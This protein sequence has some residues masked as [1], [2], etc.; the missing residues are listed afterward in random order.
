MKTR[1]LRLQD[2]HV[3]INT[4]ADKSENDAFDLDKH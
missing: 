1:P 4:C 3:E 2:E